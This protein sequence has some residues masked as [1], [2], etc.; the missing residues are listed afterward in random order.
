MPS[1]TWL[2]RAPRLHRNNSRANRRAIAARAVDDR[3]K[4]LSFGGLVE[5]RLRD[6]VDVDLHAPRPWRVLLAGA[7]S[8]ANV[9]ESALRA[10]AAHLL[11]VEFR[12][13]CDT[14]R[15]IEGEGLAGLRCLRIDRLTF[16]VLQAVR[17]AG[18]R[19]FDHDAHADFGLLWPGHW[20]PSCRNGNECL[21]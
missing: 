1:E 9:D 18:D 10:F 20:S 5:L 2:N 4:R 6:G 11:A 8:D 3:F 17:D 13:C 14:D 19:R 21:A 15:K 12:A 16:L 7:L